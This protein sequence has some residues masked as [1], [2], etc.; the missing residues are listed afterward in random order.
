[1]LPLQLP[2]VLI[3]R[4]RLSLPGREV[5]AA[6]V[7]NGDRVDRA[8]AAIL[9]V[10]REPPPLLTIGLIQAVNAAVTRSEVNELMHDRPAGFDATI[11]FVAPDLVARP[12]VQTVERLVLA[13]EVHV[14]LGGD[15]RAEDP[16]ARLEGP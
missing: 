6:L 4:V 3:D 15:G 14:R 16:P 10:G 11:R 5:H 12:L 7:E 9:F 2:R 13:A 8:V 1:D